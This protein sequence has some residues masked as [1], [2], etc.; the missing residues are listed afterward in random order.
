MTTHSNLDQSWWA[1][2]LTYGLI[3]FLAGL[4]KFFNL[5][6]NWEA[7]LAPV[8]SS[9]VPL[10]AGTLMRG[11]GIIEMLVG[12]LILTNRTRVGGY[13][14]SAW[15]LSIAVNLLLTGSYFDVAV[16]DVGLA[17]GAWA[18]ARLTEVRH[19]A[20]AKVVARSGARSAGAEA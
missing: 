15:L 7:Y 3:A 18:L 4:D 9:F 19:P 8:V 13:I 20:P 17:V 11:V 6:A 1:L 10:S 12:L 14:A 16:R 2:R 5:L